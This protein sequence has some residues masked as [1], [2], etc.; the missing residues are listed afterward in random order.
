[1]K[2]VI[3]NNLFPPDERGGAEKVAL[4]QATEIV[5]TG[6]RVVLI[7]TKPIGSQPTSNC[8]GIPI[9]HLNSHYLSLTDWPFLIRPF[10]HLANIFSWCKFLQL[11][12]IL[13][14]EKP[15]LVIT[16]NLMGIGFMTPLVL[17]Q[18][19]IKQEHWLHDIQLIHPSGLMIVGQEN[20]LHSLG[21][22]LYQLL[23]R[24][25]FLSPETIKSP[26][27]WLLAEHRQRNFFTKSQAEII[28]WP[29]N[30]P[31]NK[32]QKTGPPKK[33]LFVGQLDNHKGADLLIKAF[34]KINQPDLSLEIVG[35]G[36]DQ[37]K[38]KKLAAPNRRIVFSG[39]QPTTEV[40]KKMTASDLLIVPS[41]CYENSPTVIHEAHSVGLP[42]LAAASGGIPEIINDN[43]Q[44]FKA[45][46]EP[47]LIEKISCLS[48]GKL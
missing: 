35:V 43:D 2:V 12:K 18:L 19:K 46:D 47:D 45:G 41:L 38:L 30:A 3:I 21:A 25:L 32:I 16:H 28:T 13:I 33:L 1:M 48:Q 14:F 23:T 17:R 4:R 39:R 5:K 24:R 10:W 40:L 11:K 22:R 31:Q 26:S 37:E 27:H 7:A 36:L 42:V 9:Y 15:D 34:L 8:Q 20:K 29:I 6:H 44:L